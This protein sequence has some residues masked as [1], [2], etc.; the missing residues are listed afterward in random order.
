MTSTLRKWQDTGKS[1]AVESVNPARAQTRYGPVA[2]ATI[3]ACK[4]LHR[5]TPSSQNTRIG[6]SL[7]RVIPR[8]HPMKQLGQGGYSYASA[9][10]RV[11][12]RFAQAPQAAS[13][14]GSQDPAPV[15]YH[16]SRSSSAPSCTTL[17]PLPTQHLASIPTSPRQL[18]IKPC[19]K[20]ATTTTNVSPALHLHSMQD[21]HTAEYG[22]VA[23]AR[24][25]LAK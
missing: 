11:R 19:Q 13:A 2:P 6:G 24:H 10:S 17:N 16:R 20:R 15:I 18:P 14:K 9:S 3:R 7:K 4:E 1:S 22:I 5:S 12:M 21:S 8:Q 25:S 23:N